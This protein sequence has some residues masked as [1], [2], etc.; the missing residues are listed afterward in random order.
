ME[1]KLIDRF[2]TSSIFKEI[3]NANNKWYIKKEKLTMRLGK[4]KK[5]TKEGKGLKT[6]TL[7][8]L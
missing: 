5:K 7:N 6:L 4:D 8:K 3:K 1:C 2:S